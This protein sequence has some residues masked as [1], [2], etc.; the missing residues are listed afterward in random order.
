MASDPRSPRRRVASAGGQRGARSGSSDGLGGGSQ[1]SSGKRQRPHGDGR[2]GSGRSSPRPSGRQA[3]EV[4][5]GAERLAPRTG[6]EVAAVVLHRVCSQGAF[7]M[8][9]L[10]ATIQR[11]GLDERDGALATEIVYGTLRVL[12]AIDARLAPR[13]RRG[14]GQTDPLTLAVLRAAVYQLQHLGRLPVHAIVDEAVG[15]VRTTRS[16]QSAGFVNAVLRREAEERPRDPQPPDRVMF[17]AWLQAALQ[18]SLGAARASAFCA[19]RAFPPPLCLA[20]ADRNAEEWVERLRMQ[21]P[22]AQVSAGALSP[23]SVVLRRSGDVRRLAAY[24]A[25]GFWVQE[26][27]AQLVALAVEPQAGERIG[28]LCAGHGGKSLCLQALR[29][30]EGP[31]TAVDV[32]ETK[33]SH[34]EREF[35]RLGFS[36]QQL[37][38]APVDLTVG[39]GGISPLF[40]RVLVD[41]PCSGLG[42][43][44]RRP[45][46]L[47]RVTPDDPLR[48]QALQ[49]RIVRHASELVRDGGHLFVAVCSPLKEEGV[50]LA[51]RLLVE[52]PALEMLA[53]DVSRLGILADDD[54]VLRIGP[55]LGRGD[56][57]PDAYQVLR[58]AVRRI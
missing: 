56:S 13:V 3:K 44:A 36:A 34:I 14:L 17:P 40:D 49:A 57:V 32:D 12:P 53:A 9:A 35:V 24:E 5:D 15:F 11:A 54:K 47:L 28:D 39:S 55:W 38:L 33:L 10:D 29:G 37:E 7:A 4:P 2:K 25:G 26:E 1:K 48:F 43:V 22:S 8:R 18:A 45:E 41:A 21:L 51:A 16:V 42:T 23:L 27:G 58:F 6:R 20:V 19:P 50:E 31:L 46:L 52:N 30:G